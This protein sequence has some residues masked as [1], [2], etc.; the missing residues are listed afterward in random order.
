MLLR[1]TPIRNKLHSHFLYL[2][3]YSINTVYIP[4]CL[5]ASPGQKMFRRSLQESIWDDFCNTLGQTHGFCCWGPTCKS[6]HW[7]LCCDLPLCRCLVSGNKENATWACTDTLCCSAEFNLPLVPGL[8]KTKW[9]SGVLGLD[10]VTHMKKEQVRWVTRAWLVIVA[11]MWVLSLCVPTIPTLSSPDHL[12]SSEELLFVC[13]HL[14]T[15]K[16][17]SL[18]TPPGQGSSFYS[19]HL[20]LLS[21]VKLYVISCILNL[22]SI[23]C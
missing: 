22:F 5:F 20:L 2:Q 13:T 7:G 9:W 18:R 21:I 17:H 6:F 11:G 12:Q 1:F 19:E 3:C 23:Y 14:V 10:Q 8:I 4:A 16:T 15:L